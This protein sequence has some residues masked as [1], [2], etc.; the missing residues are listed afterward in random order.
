MDTVEKYTTKYFGEVELAIE[1]DGHWADF[2]TMYNGQEITVSFSDYSIY[3]DKIKVC[4]EIIDKYILINEIA[5]KAIIENFPHKKGLVN[6]Y[7][8]CHFEDMLED[9]E[10]IE[11]FGVKNFKKLDIQKTV[12]KMEYPNLDFYIEDN[13][14]TL[15]I[16]YRVS[17]EYF[18]DD[19]FLAVK[20]SKKLNVIGFSILD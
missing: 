7:F 19:T 2:V 1:K 13:E 9:E 20:M 4:W 6:Y 14:I 3:G 15:Y 12:D 11:I 17:K 16:G 8:K 5:K 10:L 18:F